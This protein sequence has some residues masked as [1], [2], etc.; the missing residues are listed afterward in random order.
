MQT[1][2]FLA[3]PN[4]PF[5]CL[6][7]TFSPDFDLLESHNHGPDGSLASLALGKQV[8]KLRDDSAA[9]R[10]AAGVHQCHVRQH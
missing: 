1:A 2:L 9:Q 5:L 7:L 3:K 8:P 6:L 4:C 10:S